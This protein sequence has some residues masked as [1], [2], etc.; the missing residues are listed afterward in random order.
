[1]PTISRTREGGSVRIHL[2]DHRPPH[3]H[4]VSRECE[5]RFG[6]LRDRKRACL[7]ENFG[8]T[9]SQLES[10]QRQLTVRIAFLCDRWNEIHG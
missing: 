8:F 5:A 6:L 7:L 4:V 10:I 9:R 1:M 3:V 2:N